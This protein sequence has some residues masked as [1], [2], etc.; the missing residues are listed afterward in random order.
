MI[1]I[2]LNVFCALLVDPVGESLEQDMKESV[3]ERKKVNESSYVVWTDVHGRYFPTKLL[4]HVHD[5]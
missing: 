4:N 2:S 1:F 5:P 3:Y